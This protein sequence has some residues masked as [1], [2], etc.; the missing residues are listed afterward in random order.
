ME[1]Y[2]CDPVELSE[3][4]VR[5]YLVHCRDVKGWNH[6]TL[7]IALTSLKFYYTH[8]DGTSWNI[9]DLAKPPRYKPEITV[10]TMREVRAIIGQIQLIH[11]R[12]AVSLMAS[13]GLRVSEVVSVGPRDLSQREGHLL[14]RAGK[15]QKD[16]YVPLPE[17][18]VPHL[19]ELWKTHRN[20]KLLF[21]GGRGREM[22]WLR[23]T[24]TPMTI[25]TLQRIV[26]VLHTWTRQL[27]YHPHI[28]CIVPAGALS[29]DGRRW[30]SGKK[31]DFLFAHKAFRQHYRKLMQDA[32]TKTPYWSSIPK[33][34]W[35]EAWA[36]QF[37]PVG[38]ARMALAYLARYVNKTA[39]SES[40]ILWHRDGKICFSYTD[41]TTK[42][43]KT[44]TL[45]EQEFL[46]RF[47]QHVLPPGFMRIRYYGLYHHSQKHRLARAY[48]G[49]GAHAPEP[50]TPE[51]HPGNYT[52]PHCDS[53][54]QLID[55]FR[56]LRNYRPRGPPLT[57]I[58][59]S[60]S[61]VSR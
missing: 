15:G 24:T 30:R 9:W 31:P 21:P 13:C 20:A 44:C 57:P 41:S 7:N 42:Q 19:R 50:P 6:W 25:A 61:L 5:D 12:V 47:F 28:H 54:M 46:R 10:L 17:V 52:C 58:S 3:K 56:P 11:L 2:Q 18:L 1:H 37:Q 51:A 43:T 40:R 55:T 48:L 35:R 34:V 26:S 27:V 23:T 14:V 60:K 49:E 45:D 16:R 32:F 29:E 39:I 38:N 53:P 4:Q 59:K 36:V 22:K 8:G 33:Q